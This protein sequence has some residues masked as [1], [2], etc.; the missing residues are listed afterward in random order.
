MPHL[1]HDGGFC[2][3]LLRLRRRIFYH[4]AHDKFPW[5]AVKFTGTDSHKCDSVTVCLVHI[6]L[7]LKYK[8]REI[9]IHGSISPSYGL[10]AEVGML[11]SSGNV[12]E[13]FHTKVCQRRSEEYRWR[14]SFCLPAPSKSIILKSRPEARFIP[15][16]IFLI[17]IHN[18]IC[19]AVITSFRFLCTFGD[20]V[21]EKGQIFVLR[22]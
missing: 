20:C 9:I 6:C 22:S 5:E 14:F 2:H 7:I 11:S 1:P 16:E 18:L 10:Y 8:R 3:H 12:P 17:R 15:A 13:M 19:P 4:P 21:S